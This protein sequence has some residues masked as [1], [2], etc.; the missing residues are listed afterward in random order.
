MTGRDC[1]FSDLDPGYCLV[2]MCYLSDD[3]HPHVWEHCSA[4]YDGDDDC[5]E[6]AKY[7]ENGELL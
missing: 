4:Q 3:K 7:D 6:C 1:Q 2:H 5:P